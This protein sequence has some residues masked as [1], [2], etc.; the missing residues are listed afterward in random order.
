MSKRLLSRAANASP[1]THRLTEALMQARSTGAQVV[2]ATRAALDQLA[3]TYV[4]RSA[5]PNVANGGRRRVR[6][7]RWGWIAA[8]AC[9]DVELYLVILR[10]INDNEFLV[11]GYF[12][13]VGT[14]LAAID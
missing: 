1:Q 12:A 7:S 13:I 14:L 4:D 2:P 11:Y 10:L 6:M 5:E 3:E 9:I 8:L